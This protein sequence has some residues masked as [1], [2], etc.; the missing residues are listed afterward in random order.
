MNY[1]G[2]LTQVLTPKQGI[3]AIVQSAKTFTVR[4]FGVH[5]LTL[6]TAWQGPVKSAK[7]LP[8]AS[9][10]NAM[11]KS[12]KEVIA[13]FIDRKAKKSGNVSTDGLTVL[14]FGNPIAKRE[15][16]RLLVS[17]AGWETRTTAAVLNCLPGVCIN[18]KQ[19]RFLFNGQ[20]WENSHQW[21]AVES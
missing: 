4:R 11:R 14:L 19:G 21:K 16:E 20:K 6:W 7:N 15:G 5:L 13:A 12:H 1:F 10:F 9:R 18:S 3:M 17:S 2:N 8:T